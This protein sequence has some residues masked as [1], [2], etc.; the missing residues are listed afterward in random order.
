MT[1]L[2]PEEQKMQRARLRAEM[3]APTRIL[4]LG[5]YGTFAAM[6][7]IGTLSFLSRTLASIGETT[8]FTNFFWTLAHVGLIAAMVGL[9]RL[10]KGKD[11][12]LYE[13][14]LA[15]EQRH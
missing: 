4:R 2:T 15:E 10:E 9:Y 6:G 8:F 11:Q 13:K 14:F 7:L 1:T 3:K 12:A 5:I